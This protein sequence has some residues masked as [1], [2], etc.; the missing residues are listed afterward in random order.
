MGR[1]ASV[2][3][4]HNYANYLPELRKM[5]QS[6]ADYP[7]GLRRGAEVVGIGVVRVA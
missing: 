2:R 7:D 3:A 1:L 5:M 6:W 4:A